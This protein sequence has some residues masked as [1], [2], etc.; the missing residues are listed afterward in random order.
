MSEARADAAEFLLPRRFGGFAGFWRWPLSSPSGELAGILLLW[1]L[2]LIVS[3]WNGFPLIFY[4]TGAYIF[5]GFGNRFVAERSPVYSLFLVF[6]G[7]G[8]SLWLVVLVQAALTAFVMVET[9]RCVAPRMHLGLLAAIGG[10]LVLLT[11]L[12]WYAGQIEPDC[13][14]ALVVLSLYLLAFYAGRLGTWRTVALVAIAALATGAHPSHLGL[15]AGLV[16]VLAVYELTIRFH[17]AA[18][19][20]RANLTLPV[21]SAVL[22]FALVFAGNY[23]FTRHVFI[24][25][26]GPVFVFARMLQDG[27]VKDLLNDT[28]PESHYALCA[29]RNALPDRADKW[30]WGPRTPFLALHRFDGTEN[31]SERIVLDSLKRYPLLNLGLAL[32]DS[33]QQFMTFRTGDQIEPQQWVLY[34]DFHTYIPGQLRA[35]ASAR[36]QKGGIDFRPVNA[37]HE[38]IGWLALAFLVAMLAM[39][40]REKD[41]KSAALLGF[42]LAA[43]LGNAVIC[44]A[45]SNPHA[46]Y[47]SRLIWVPAFAL[48]LLASE[49]RLLR[50]A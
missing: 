22:G 6:T 34:P 31:E 19:W 46:R 35:Y 9:A 43:L 32:R 24:S 29:Y 33:I 40:W 38:P 3:L 26:A 39:A 48:I 1:P 25:K 14:T 5:E 28:C 21:V 45:L 27:L 20:P 44:G 13:L 17:R 49:R 2:L 50:D 18:S 10:A 16:A 36:Q 47:Q 42:V 8:W 30:L 23:H 12:P 15:A 41:A 7:G 37:V 4:D 11:G